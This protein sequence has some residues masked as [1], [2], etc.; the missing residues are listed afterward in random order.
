MESSDNSPLLSYHIRMVLK[1]KNKITLNKVHSM[2]N[3]ER[4]P[5]I[6]WLEAVAT[7][8]MLIVDHRHSMKTD[9]PC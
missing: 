1:K 6:L 2:F 5:K 7:A 9:E 4:V 3:G 8:I